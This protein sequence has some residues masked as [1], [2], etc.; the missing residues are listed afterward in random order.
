[1]DE[2]QRGKKIMTPTWTANKQNIKFE[3]MSCRLLPGWHDGHHDHHQLK[4]QHHPHEHQQHH[5]YHHLVGNGG[6]RAQEAKDEIWMGFTGLS[7]KFVNCIC[8]ACI[9]LTGLSWKFIGSFVID[10]PSIWIY[11]YSLQSP[12]AYKIDI[13]NSLQKLSLWVTSHLGAPGLFMH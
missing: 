9:C 4:Q 1:M 5:H 6:V 13:K 7:L 8:F 11:L 10:I 12:C 3:K 2:N